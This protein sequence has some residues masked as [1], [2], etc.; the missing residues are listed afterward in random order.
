MPL[1]EA[2]DSQEV[3]LDIRSGKLDLHQAESLP[4]LQGLFARDVVSWATIA[5]LRGPRRLEAGLEALKICRPAGIGPSTEWGTI[6][7]EQLDFVAD[8]VARL[9]E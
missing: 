4:Q 3:A 5:V 8:Q 7:A 9:R 6:S 1:V 2:R